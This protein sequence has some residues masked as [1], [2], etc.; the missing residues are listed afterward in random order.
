MFQISANRAFLIQRDETSF[1]GSPAKRANVNDPNKS[2]E[3]EQM[4]NER[5]D[6]KILTGVSS[7]VKNSHQPLNEMEWDLNQ[8]VLN[9]TNITLPPILQPVEYNQMYVS[10]LNDTL[11]ATD[12]GKSI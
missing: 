1:S 3:S 2:S 4:S 11:D 10:S 8:R 5:N 6:T 9:T 7:T 12:K